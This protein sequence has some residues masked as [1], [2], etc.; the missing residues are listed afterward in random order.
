MNDHHAQYPSPCALH[1][2]RLQ[3]NRHYPSTF[4]T[5][6]GVANKYGLNRHQG[7]VR[8]VEAMRTYLARHHPMEAELRGTFVAV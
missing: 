4:V 2:Y 3:A 6:Q 1:L 7:S 5:Q 8:A